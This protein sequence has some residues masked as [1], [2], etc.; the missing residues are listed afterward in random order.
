MR[1]IVD[2]PYTPEEKRVSDYI[3]EITGGLVGSGDDPIG[4]LLAS[5]AQL[6]FD[7][8]DLKRQLEDAR[9]ELSFY[10]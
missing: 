5:H 2:R 4:F 10:G 7:H 8:D 6:R 1:S 9:R 3:Q